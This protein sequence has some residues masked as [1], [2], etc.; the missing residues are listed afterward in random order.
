MARY[1]AFVVASAALF[2]LPACLALIDTTSVSAS[3][4]SA[5]V[6]AEPFGFAAGGYMDFEVDISERCVL[7]PPPC[8]V[9]VVCMILFPRQVLPGTTY[10]LF[11]YKS[12]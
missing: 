8:S 11:L 7:V 2:S 6:L 9:G 10:T 3:G 12:R 5:T 4:V 1:A